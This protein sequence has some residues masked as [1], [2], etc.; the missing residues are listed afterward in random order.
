M[1]MHRLT[2]TLM[3]GLAFLGSMTNESS[4][5]TMKTGDVA[6]RGL[7]ERDFPR[8]QQ[9]APGVYSYEALRNGDP[10]GKMTTVSLIVI[11]SDGVLVADGQGNAA[12][13][14][15]MVDWIAK[16]TTQPIKY[17]V[18]CSDHGDHTGGNSAFPAGVTYL[19]TPTSARVLAGA[20]GGAPTQLD[21]VPMKRVLRMGGTAVEVLNLGRAHTGGD[22]S[23]YL[24]NERVLFLSE[25]YLH[26]IFPA[27]RSAHPTEWVGT[28]RK[29]EALDAVWYVPGHGFVDDAATLKADL[30]A[31]RRAVE[32]VIAES[33]RLYN[34]RIPC[35]APPPAARAPTTGA[36]PPP[37][38]PCQA[39]ALGEWGDL[40]NW[41]LFASQLEVAIRRVY[42]ELDGK[43]PP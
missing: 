7:S 33:A 35:P 18:V 28:L 32:Q 42:D 14:K 41:T 20:P 22:L 5:Q 34:A 13:T 11:T 6:K 36:A 19:A 39:A 27:M 17:V 37:R 26:W 40:A 4:A 10:G 24:P 9:L 3:F 31:Y 43:L 29:A 12:Q 16:T 21:T 38:E 1:K 30:P 15:E 23:V 2:A 25:A 8:T